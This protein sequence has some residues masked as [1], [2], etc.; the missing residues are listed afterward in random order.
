M[1]VGLLTALLVSC[2]AS[3]DPEP[4]AWATMANRG[5]VSAQAPS[6]TTPAGNTSTST[7]STSSSTTTLVEI[8]A[9]HWV[10]VA[11][12]LGD[13]LGTYREPGGDP[14][15][16]FLS[17]GPGDGP[18]VVRVLD[19]SDPDW[20]QVALP[21]KPNG[22]TGWVL[23]SAV[24]LSTHA[25]RVE[26]DLGEHTLQAWLDGELIADAV[27]AIGAVDSPTPVGTFFL[28]HKETLTAQ[29]PVFG[30]RILGT[31]GFSE[32]LPIVDGGVP[33]VAIHEAVDLSLL[34]QAVS[35]GCLRVAPEV[36]EALFAL[37]LGALV[38][39]SD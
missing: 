12:A 23:R 35:L 8:P 3:G 11:T 26:I 9:N 29:D 14:W 7:T 18:R 4:S 31:S 39:V 13:S 36:A 10:Q 2:S 25:A 30:H 24:E 16:E 27:V 32:V 6:T 33:A 20:L 5:P 15:W 19:D 21:V 34:G 38:V 28:I 37:P 22:T 17:P 1:A